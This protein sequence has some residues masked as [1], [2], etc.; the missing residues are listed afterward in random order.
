MNLNGNNYYYIRNAQGDII[1]LID[2]TGTQVVSYTY[3]TW[4]KLIS[5]SGSLK[6][7]VGVLN[8]YRYR[9]YRY[10]TETGF[11]YLQ[12]RYYN[13]EWGRFIN[14]DDTDQLDDTNEDLLDYNMFTYCNNNSVNKADNDGR[15]AYALYFVPGIGA[16][17]LGI[18]A[19]GFA[20]YGTYKILS[21]VR[22]RIRNYNFA[23]KIRSKSPPARRVKCK[24]RKEAKQRA[25][26]AGKGRKP[27]GP[28]NHGGGW[29]YHPNVPK[30]QRTTPKGYSSH[31]HFYYY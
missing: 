27:R 19:V 4:G 18:T 20:A 29:H 17:L 3:D 31:D 16:V 25:T 10:D 12:S 11:Y 26:R 6:D 1:G 14:A 30:A 2:S 21:R 7:T 23:S 15:F 22:N 13:P 5:I 28:E 24:S 8:P 9:G